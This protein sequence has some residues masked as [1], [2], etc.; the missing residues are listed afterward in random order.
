MNCKMLD[1]G[2]QIAGPCCTIFS[3]ALENCD[4]LKRLEFGEGVVEIG[5]NCFRG[6]MIVCVAA[7]RS[8]NVPPAPTAQK[9]TALIPPPPAREVEVLL[10][11]HALAARELLLR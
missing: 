7:L 2:V 5:P 6:S 11:C 4:Q 1:E 8:L 3:G 9:K 10:H